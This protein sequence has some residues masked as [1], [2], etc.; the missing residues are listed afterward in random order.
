MKHAVAIVLA[1][2]AGAACAQA[3]AYPTKSIRVVIALAHEL[4]HIQDLRQL[5]GK[6]LPSFM[7]EGR[8]LTIGQACRLHIWQTP[9]DYDRQ[10]ARSAATFTPEQAME[11]LENFRGH[12]WNNQ[13]IGTVV[14]E[15]MRARWNGGIADINLRLSRM[16]ERIAAGREFEPA[17]QDE[18]KVSADAFA[19]AFTTFLR[20]TQN[21]PQQRLQG[22]I[23]MWQSVAAEA[24][25]AKASQTAQGGCVG[26]VVEIIGEV[27]WW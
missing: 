18:F 3:P 27:L 11:L 21:N 2:A 8:A 4:T 20:T 23:T 12:G 22:T 9:G 14:V 19:E 24:L 5:R 15:Y 17:F 13:A 10:M 26:D 1:F 6:R 7:L 16:I 25:T